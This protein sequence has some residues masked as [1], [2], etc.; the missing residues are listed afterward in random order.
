MIDAARADAVEEENLT[1]RHLFPFHVFALACYLVFGAADSCWIPVPGT[2]GES[3]S[4]YCYVSVACCL[5]LIGGRVA[6]HRMEDTRLARRIL[7]SVWCGFLVAIALSGFEAYPSEQPTI[8]AWV[9]GMA[10]LNAIVAINF[11]VFGM[12]HGSV[13]L[14]HGWVFAWSLLT[15]TTCGGTSVAHDLL[16]GGPIRD[17]ATI[18]AWLGAYY[19]GL[20]TMLLVVH[21][22][23]R[24]YA[25]V[26][27]RMEQLRRSK[28]RLTYDL[29]AACHTADKYRNVLSERGLPAPRGPAASRSDGEVV[30]APAPASG[31]GRIAIANADDSRSCAESH[32]T[33]SDMLT[34]ERDV[35]ALIDAD[36]GTDGSDAEEV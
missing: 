1:F 12:L 18:A 35:P 17:G 36:N 23:I 10:G 24:H 9:H 21:P 3:A 20:L 27:E 31:A 14:S 19:G 6:I 22:L 26:D 28:D 13:G 16:V 2:D 34:I 15:V 33:M 8:D 25:K 11:L 7:S 30:R 4:I 32:D 5:L 29:A